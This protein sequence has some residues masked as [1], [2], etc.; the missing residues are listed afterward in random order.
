MNLNELKYFQK[1]QLKC[2]DT[3]ALPMSVLLKSI[4]VK[5]RRKTWGKL[6]DKRSRLVWTVDM[7]S[8][9]VGPF[10]NIRDYKERKAIRSIL[11]R[12]DKEYPINSACEVGCG[13]GR[14]IMVMEEYAKRV[15]GFEREQH[16]VDIAKE[17][18]PAIDFCKIDSLDKLSG[19]GKCQFDFVMTCTVLQHLTDDLCKAVLEEIKR[20]APKGHILL[21]EKAEDNF[22]TKNVTDGDS[23]I[24][25]ARSV[26]T[27][28][29]WMA[30]YKLVSVTKRSVEPGYF[31]PNVGECML[32][33]SPLL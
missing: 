13:Y 24:S 1:M 22:T 16:L 31:N 20:I 25:R 15:V 7:V 28:G 30:P 3:T 2:F 10:A 26:E 14:L 23:F 18:L 6:L 19:F 4:L 33:K 5:V 29:S 12:I 17:L 27:Y 9:A 11:D 8:D 32:F 21:I